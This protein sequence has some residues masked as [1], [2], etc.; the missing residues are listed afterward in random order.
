M[1]PIS[2]IYS[3]ER[4]SFFHFMVEISAIIGGIFTLAR[5][6]DSFLYKIFKNI[7]THPEITFPGIELAFLKVIAICAIEVTR[8]PRRFKHYMKSRW[9]VKF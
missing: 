4:E 8:R 1:S 7:L 2:V 6:F 5:V 3:I 9:P